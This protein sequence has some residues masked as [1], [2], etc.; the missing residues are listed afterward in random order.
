MDLSKAATNL[1]QEIKLH[2]ELPYVKVNTTYTS[3]APP[4]DHLGNN[5]K[6]FSNNGI[7]VVL[8]TK[9]ASE[10]LKLNEI[11][12]E[13]KIFDEVVS[14]DNI[15]FLYGSRSDENVDWQNIDQRFEERTNQKSQI[16][17]QCCN[18]CA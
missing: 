14:D 15:F 12:K 18:C 11:L 3:D 9:T 6:I 17:S 13:K 5:S 1:Q 10:A 4:L 2:C 8:P 7:N 16:G